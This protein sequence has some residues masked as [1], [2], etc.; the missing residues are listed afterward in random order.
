MVKVP[1]SLI[2]CSVPSGACA[3][4]AVEPRAIQPMTAM[5]LVEW[6][7][8]DPPR[9]AWSNP[10]IDRIVAAGKIR[11]HCG[12]A[13]IS[14]PG[15]GMACRSPSLGVELRDRKEGPSDAE[16]RNQPNSH[17]VDRPRDE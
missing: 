1:V 10:S 4:A 9:F 14:H 2:F 13:N 3:L 7:M 8:S 17:P 12:I 16:H 5:M 11:G 6:R 15:V